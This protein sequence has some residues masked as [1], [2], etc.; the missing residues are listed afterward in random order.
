MNSLTKSPSLFGIF[1]IFFGLNVSA[2]ESRIVDSAGMFSPDVQR[3]S[4]ARLKEIQ[5][6]SGFASLIQT[7]TDSGGQ[8]PAKLAVSLA[9]TEAKKG[10]FVLILKNER[11]IEI[12]WSSELS[13]KMT[14]D[15]RD[16]IRNAITGEFRKGNYDAGLISGV[17]SIVTLSQRISVAKPPLSG[18]KNAPQAPGP[19][20]PKAKPGLS[21]G[22]I[23]FLAFGFLILMGVMRSL[24]APRSYTNGMPPGRGPGMGPGNY[25]GGYGGGGYGGGGGLFSGVLGGLGGALLGNWAYDRFA[26][27]SHDH[28]NS[29]NDPAQGGMLGGNWGESGGAD[30]S[31]SDNQWF[32]ADDGGDWGGSGSGDDGGWSGMDSGGDWSG[33]DFGS[34]SGSDW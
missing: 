5:K 1:L 19:A 12:L 14:N 29:M 11:K 6:S 2:Q 32:G 25:Q 4:E 20:V 23:L 9:K 8:D 18:L 3:S 16:Q 33:G 13:G 22:S 27:G 21:I 30:S 10:L 24:F 26:R 28:H 17:N 31:G 34:S 15:D 7:R